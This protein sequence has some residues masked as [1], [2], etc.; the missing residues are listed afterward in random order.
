MIKHSNFAF[1]VMTPKE[2]HVSTIF[3]K[4][5]EKVEHCTIFHS[6]NNHEY[7]W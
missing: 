6:Q 5:L 2:G 7:S 3:Q 1:Q 4:F